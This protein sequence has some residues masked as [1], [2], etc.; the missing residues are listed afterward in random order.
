MPQTVTAEVKGLK[1]LNAA[2][3]QLTA[4]IRTRSLRNAARAGA[5]VIRD[6]A[7]GLVPVRSG[8]LKKAIV[9]KRSA[10]ESKDG[11]EVAKVGISSL[12]LRSGVKVK[13]KAKGRKR[14]KN[15]EPNPIIYGRFL[16]F[17]T[18]KMSPRPFL[19]PAFDSGKTA[20]VDAIAAKLKDEIARP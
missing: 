8:A 9:V 14:A 19:A 16:E 3:N 7:K 12:V 20:A 11:L 4:K 15:S 5:V 13:S 17:G 6:K 1:E 2:L 18:S 10:S